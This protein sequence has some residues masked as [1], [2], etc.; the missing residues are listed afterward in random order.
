MRLI[1][2]TVNHLQQMLTYSAAIIIVHYLFAGWRFECVSTMMP[3]EVVL[4]RNTGSLNLIIWENRN[5]AAPKSIS[6]S[7]K[8]IC[9]FPFF[10]ILILLLIGSWCW[11]WSSISLAAM[12][13]WRCEMVTASARVLSVDSVGTT[14]LPQ[15][16]ALATVCT[17]SLCLMVTR[18]SMD[19]LP[20][21]RRAQAGQILVI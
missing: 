9:V 18:I 17:Y 10:V 8:F 13:T 21:S 2:H 1:S 14:D 4:P 5:I 16:R 19:S 3:A 7:I 11:V 20:L 6:N 12:T 15:F